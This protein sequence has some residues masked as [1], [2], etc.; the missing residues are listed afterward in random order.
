MTS[1]FG[2]QGSSHLVTYMQLLHSAVTPG[3]ASGLAT[4]HFC[5]PIPARAAREEE[6]A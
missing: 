6:L 5:N 1:H 2:K 4:F 3:V